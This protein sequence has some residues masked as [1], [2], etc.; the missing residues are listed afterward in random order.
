LLSSRVITTALVAG[1]LTVALA[2]CG[3]GNSKSTTAQKSGSATKK[4]TVGYSNLGEDQ[5]QLIEQQKAVQEIKK[6]GLTALPPVSA[7]KDPGKQL[8][9]IHTLVSQGAN[10]IMVT[11]VDSAAIKPAINFLSSKG[12][13]AVS[14]DI[15]P[16]G[17]KVA[18]VVRADNLKM[19]A[20]ACKQMGTALHGKGTVLSL[21]GDYKTTNGHDRGEGFLQC[22]KGDYPGIKIID[23]HMDWNTDKCA[24]IAN[25]I[26][27]TNKAI[28]GVYMASDTICLAPVLSALKAAGRDA[29]VGA[30]GHVYMVSIDGSP[31]GLKMVRAGK[32]DALLS[33]PLDLYAKYG[34]DYL[35]R[36][37]AGEKFKLGPTDHGS[38]IINDA[39]NLEDALPAPLVT[40]KNAADPS[41]W[42]NGVNQ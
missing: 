3:S 40:K 41:L 30:P 13:P 22:M 4:I 25:T 10:G 35:K 29:P 16:Q 21:E 33:Q 26:L 8:S 11:P 34:V 9:D 5:F 1:S 39:G 7:N 36:A 6:Q 15:S 18:M 38:K 37:A 23:R 24:S 27:R 32:L 28:N 12:I 31:F 2:A 20:D 14:I 17:S 42:G 19:G